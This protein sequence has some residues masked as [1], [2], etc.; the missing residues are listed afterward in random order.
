MTRTVE[1]SGIKT[2]RRQMLKGLAAATGAGAGSG[3]ITGFPTIWAQNIKDIVI[4]QIGSST[5]TNKLVE[6]Q[7][8]K[9]LPFKLQLTPLDGNTLVARA[10]TQP[11]TWDIVNDGPPD[12]PLLWP[13][14]NFQTID[15]KRIPWWSKVVPLYTTGKIDPA[16]KFGQG[17]NPSLVMHADAPGNA[18]T[19]V[20]EQTPYLT[21]VPTLHNADTLGIRP[22]LVGPKPVTSWGDLLRP[23]FK[24][25]TALCNIPSVGLFDAASALQAVGLVKYVDMGDMTKDEID[26]T[27]KALI[28]FK[29]AGHFRAFWAAYEESINL[30]ATGD[31]VIQSMWSPAVTA[32]RSQGVPCLYQN[33]KEGYRCWSNALFVNAQASGMLLDAIYEYLAWYHESGFP[34]SLFTRQG[35]YSA[36]QETAR[37]KM[38]PEEWAYWMQGQPAAIDIV[39]PYGHTIEKKGNVRTGGSYQERLGNVNVWNTVMRENEYQLSRW[40]DFI[41]A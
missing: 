22:D 18:G 1:K 30:M 20:K 7:A 35:Y 36:V 34:G 38:K 9:D 21:C 12:I 19:P 26:A 40:N 10:V 17:L 29:K 37:A 5:D 32:V 33:L 4:R 14:K 3:A 31:V 13:T 24:G 25:K 16:A 11:D 23:E 41:S 27:V 15:V 8:N 6:D 28:E 2:T 39:D